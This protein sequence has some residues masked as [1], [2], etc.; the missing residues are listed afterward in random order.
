MCD[1]KICCKT[2]VELNRCLPDVKCLPELPTGTGRY[3]Y[4]QLILNKGKVS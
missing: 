3:T 2:H 4:A 1:N